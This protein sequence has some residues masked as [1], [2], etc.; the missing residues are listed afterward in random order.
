MKIDEILKNNNLE[1]EYETH[2]ADDLDDLA[3]Y[4]YAREIE[5]DD[6]I[7]IGKDQYGR[8]EAMYRRWK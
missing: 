6:I 2:L 4:L 1:Y 7:Y 3:K 5:S 8:P